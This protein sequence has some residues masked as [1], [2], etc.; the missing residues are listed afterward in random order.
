VVVSLVF[1]KRFLAAIAFVV[2][3]LS[4]DIGVVDLGHNVL[5]TATKLQVEQVW[6]ILKEMED[7]AL[8]IVLVFFEGRGLGF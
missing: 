6:P 3:L 7:E 1:F 8:V 4:F 2:V 5:K